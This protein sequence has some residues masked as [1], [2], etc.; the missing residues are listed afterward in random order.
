MT[1]PSVG[2]DP[3]TFPIEVEL[4][5]VRQHTDPAD[6]CHRSAYWNIPRTQT[7]I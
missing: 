4:D 2:I 6:D 7:L 1:E 3:I 5:G